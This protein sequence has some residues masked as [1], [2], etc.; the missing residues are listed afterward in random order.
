MR[1]FEG[2]SFNSVAQMCDYYGIDPST[3]SKRIAHGMTV[4]AA[5]TAPVEEH[6]RN[7]ARPRP[8]Q[9]PEIG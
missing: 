8:K 6:K 4:K 1:D 9:K 2:R 5:L 3:Y 7:H